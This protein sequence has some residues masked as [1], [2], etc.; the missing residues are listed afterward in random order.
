[1]ATLPLFMLRTVLYPH[2]PLSLHVFEERYRKMMRD[3]LEAGTTFGVVSIREGREVADQARPRDVGTLAKIVHVQ[4]LEDGRM[5]LL[6]TGASRFRILRVVEGQPYAQAEVEYLPE[7]DGEVS[8]RVRSGLRRAF[9]RYVERLQRASRTPSGPPELPEEPEALSYLVAATL[10]DSLES[11]QLLLEAPT[12]AERLA[13]ELATLRR[14]ADLTR[15]QL[16]V[17]DVELGGFSTN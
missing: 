14:E 13:M 7:E 15:R 12:A 9:G 17:A 1:M 5:N 3:C 11:S 16:V 8:D 6:V 2:M 4:R 10:D